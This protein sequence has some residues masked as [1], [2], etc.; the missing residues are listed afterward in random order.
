LPHQDK[1]LHDWDFTDKNRQYIPY[2][3]IYRILKFHVGQKWDDVVS[4]F[5]KAKWVPV[6]MR[7]YKFLTNCVTVNTFL[8]KDKICYHDNWGLTRCGTPIRCIEEDTAHNDVLYLDPTSLTLEMLPHKPFDFNKQY[9]EEKA[10]TFRIIGPYH[11]LQKINGIW[12]EV[13]IEKTSEVL[14][15]IKPFDEI[16]FKQK[17][18]TFQPKYQ[19]SLDLQKKLKD[20]GIHNY[21]K[22]FKIGVT[23]H[24]LNRSEL[25]KYN[26]TNN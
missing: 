3:R 9:K 26:L 11:Q 6:E 2:A 16:D 17:W 15:N 21:Y 13:K 25:K 19:Y 23:K 14:D 12:Y 8:E 20:A 22:T 18:I 10:K 1:H 7:T 4:K 5:C 24:Q